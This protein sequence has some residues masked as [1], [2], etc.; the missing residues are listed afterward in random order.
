MYT[1]EVADVSV[2]LSRMI[3]ELIGQF[4]ILTVGLDLA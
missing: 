4:H 3:Q 2:Y 1:Y